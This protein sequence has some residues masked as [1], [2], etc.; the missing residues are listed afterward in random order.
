VLFAIPQI[1]F[2]F[3][4]NSIMGPTFEITINFS[5]GGSLSKT[6]NIPNTLAMTGFGFISNTDDITSAVIV[7]NRH[8]LCVDNLTYA[9]IALPTLPVFEPASLAVLTTGLAGFGFAHRRRKTGRSAG[10]PHQEALRSGKSGR[11]TRCSRPDDI[12]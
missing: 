12:A 11:A 2:G 1:A 10:S 5:G 7:K 9:D 8:R 4:T 6:L 3:D